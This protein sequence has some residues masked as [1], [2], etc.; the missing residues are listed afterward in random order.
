MGFIGSL[1]CVGMCGGIT[2][3]FNQAVHQEKQL[4]LS[5]TYQ[6]FRIISYAILGALVAVFGALFTKASFPVL[7]ILSG[8]F[9]ILLGFYLVSFSAPLLGLEK[10]GHKLW[11]RVQ[12][13]QRSFLPVQT[14]SQAT[15]IGLLWGLLPCGLVYSALA[16]AVSSGSAIEG[17]IVML[18]F[19]VGTLPM[20]LSVGMASQKLLS[21]AKKQWVKNIAAMIFILL[22]IYYIYSALA[23]D[24]SHHQRNGQTIQQQD[25]SH[26]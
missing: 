4:Q 1:H 12:P 26:H 24:H 21:F 13:I 18:C 19:G 11:K 17:F 25:H 8:I 6:F 5:F 7:P 16:L 14:F 3:A 22:G 20:L 23:Q 9:M 10:L 2:V 15:I